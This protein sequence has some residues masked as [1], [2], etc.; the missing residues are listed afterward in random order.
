M[1]LLCC[2]LQLEAVAQGQGNSPYSVFGV[3]EM[4]SQASVTQ[5]AMGG[6][7]ISFS[8]GFYINTLNPALLVKNRVAGPYKYVALNVGLKGKYT[9][10]QNTTTQ[11]R[12]L[13]LN[14]NNLSM[15]FPVKKWM[16]T[17][18]AFQPYTM[19]DHKAKQTKVISGASSETV[20]FNYANSG[21]ISR[22]S[23]LNS[24]RVGKILYL[25]VDA[26][27]NFGTIFRDTTTNLST[28]T[29]SFLRYSNRTSLSGYMVRPTI[30]FQPKLNKNWNLNLG[31][32]YEFSGNLKGEN[33]RTFS[34]LSDVGNGPAL[35]RVPDTLAFSTVSTTLPPS[36]RVGISL[37]SPFKW[38]FAAEYSVK[39]WSKFR[40]IDGKASSVLNDSQ[41]FNFGIEYIPNVNST[42]YAN[43]IFYRLGYR[44]A[45]SP[46]VINGTRIHDRSVNF[47]LSMPLGFRNPSYVDYFVA[48]GKRGTTANSLI[49]EN[50]I[51]FGLN[52]SLLSVWF[53]Q[54]KID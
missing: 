34:T 42:K 17:G 28:L 50:Y 31:A 30:A 16:A 5:E 25:G 45:Q 38:V 20:D 44:Q 18:V 10:I 1:S 13:G 29:T 6:T 52:F 12:D 37:E 46:Y 23:W 43:Q 2:V 35:A 47:G 11:Q 9:T 22:V 21:G 51:K 3:G 32:S 40:D 33:L 41:E 4:A 7:G 24:V 53:T 48:I 54:P 36:Y 8:N 15:V 19:V 49:Q 26:S 14:L 27:Y 39:Q